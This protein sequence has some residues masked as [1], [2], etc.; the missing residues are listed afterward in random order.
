MTSNFSYHNPG[1]KI[2]SL[3]TSGVWCKVGKSS[4]LVIQHSDDTP[5]RN[6]PEQGFGFHHLSKLLS[7]SGYKREI[8]LSNE[9][10]PDL[11]T[12]EVSCH[13]KHPN[14]Y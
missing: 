6:L 5:L 9:Q 14:S 13:T 1:K 10:L 11:Q 4:V 12:L 8:L 7:E 3:G 2:P